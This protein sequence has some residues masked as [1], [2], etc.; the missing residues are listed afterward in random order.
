MSDRII[1]DFEQLDLEDTPVIKCEPA[2]AVR[3]DPELWSFAFSAHDI[4]LGSGAEGEDE[5]HERLDDKRLR[6]H[7]GL[8]FE[9][10]EFLER[11]K[12]RVE[13]ARLARDLLAKA[14]RE[15]AVRWC[16]FS[17]LTQDLR[18]RLGAGTPGA[19]VAGADR[20]VATTEWKSILIHGLGGRTRSERAYVEHAA[21]EVMSELAPLYGSPAP[22]WEVEFREPLASSRSLAKVDAVVIAGS[23][24][25]RPLLLDLL[26]RDSLQVEGFDA[27]HVVDFLSAVQ[28]RRG[29]GFVLYE[30]RGREALD[31]VVDAGRGPMVGIEL[32]Q[33][34]GRTAIQRSLSLVRDFDPPIVTVQVPAPSRH[35]EYATGMVRPVQ[36]AIAATLSVIERVGLDRLAPRSFLLRARGLG[37]EPRADAWLNLYD[38][39]WALG[40]EPHTGFCFAPTLDLRAGDRL[41]VERDL[42]ALVPAGSTFSGPVTNRVLAAGRLDA[43]MLVPAGAQTRE[44]FER[45][46][47]G[48]ANLLGQQGW[49]VDDRVDASGELFVE[50]QRARFVIFPLGEQRPGSDA[51]GAP[52]RDFPLGEIDR[53][54][55][56]SRASPGN[57]LARLAEM[58]ELE[59]N[60]RDLLHLPAERATIWSLLGAQ[61][62]RMM[63]GFPSRTRTDFLALLISQAFRRQDTQIDETGTLF[64]AIHSDSLGYTSHLRMRRVWWDQEVVQADVELAASER[65]EFA[66]RG[67]VL[68]RPFTLV[69]RDEGVSLRQ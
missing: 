61:V 21:L 58:P 43:M 34:M 24:E 5:L 31:R 57:V 62:Q 2:F 22:G 46:R 44:A 49:S 53:L 11:R 26:R 59:I 8:G 41:H 3:G 37:P 27:D 69:I 4:V 63:T 35:S 38:R 42:E 36:H 33:Q 29:P 56:S 39:A 23:A 13:F 67:E 68:M 28:A 18:R 65:N 52:P 17:I 19:R 54:V 32:V 47:E 40:L 1:I 30:P 20:I 55:V 16:D 51:G 7:P 60:M 66:R 64:E 6:K 45:R 14:S 10:A 25:L 48:I 9:L 15:A 12:E 50:G